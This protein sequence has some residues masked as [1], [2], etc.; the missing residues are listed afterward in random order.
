MSEPAAPAAPVAKKGLST[1]AKVAIGCLVGLMLVVGGC[2]VVTAFF[3]KKGVHAVKEFADETQKDPDLA[4][5]K[6]ALLMF[7]M[8]PDVEVVSSDA[9]AKSITVRDKKTGKETTFNLSDI[10]SGHLSIKS[11]DDEVNVEGNASPDGKSG[12]F[13]ITS[14]KGKMVLGGDGSEIPSWVPIYPGAKT[15][16]YS[17]LD[18]AEETSGTFTIHTPDAADRV[19]AYY[20][21]ALKRSGYKVEKTTMQSDKATGGN[22]TATSGNRTINIAVATQEGQ[23]Q[24][25]VAYSEKP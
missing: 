19:L 3:V 22:L 11:G 12:S 6:G 8:Q 9:K 21:N 20:E 10:K 23:S 4:A 16:G 25:L 17:S 24:G 18:S 15:D 5:Y 1:G 13:K 14:N 7:K 2:F